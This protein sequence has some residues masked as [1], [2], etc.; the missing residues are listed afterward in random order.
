MYSSEY[1]DF[2]LDRMG[3]NTYKWDW[4]RETYGKDILFLFVADMD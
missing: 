4:A 1:F 2:Q 3:T